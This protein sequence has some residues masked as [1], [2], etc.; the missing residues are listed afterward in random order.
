VLCTGSRR[1]GVR[2]RGV[3]V[4][5]FFRPFPD[6]NGALG[7]AYVNSRYRNDLIGTN[8]AAIIPALFQ[9]PGS[10]ISNS[11]EF[12]MTGSAG[13]TPEIGGTGLRGLLYADFRYQSEVNTGSDLDEEK[14]QTDVVVV[15]ARVG[16][17]GRDDRW[18]VELWAQNLFDEDY[19]Q[20]A[21]DM[22]LQGSGTIGQTRR[23]GTPA[24]QLFGAFLA[25]PRTY[26]VTVRTRF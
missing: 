23:F 8:G 1:A 12:S 21:F 9:L 17:S 19:K 25:D 7:F 18:G 26:G 2:S 14:L 10:R 15:N 6:F 22:P 11:A 24:T 5:S 3:E 13:W 16:V 20:I 4:E